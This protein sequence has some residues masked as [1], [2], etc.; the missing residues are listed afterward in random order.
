MLAVGGGE[1]KAREKKGKPM[2]AQ[3]SHK[4]FYNARTHIHRD[5]P[6]F[7]LEDNGRRHKCN[8]IITFGLQAPLMP[9]VFYSYLFTYLFKH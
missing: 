2:T 5:V 6:P 3:R 4:Y 7:C 1:R 9:S 8:L